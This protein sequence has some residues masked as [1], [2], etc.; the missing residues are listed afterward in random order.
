M[1]EVLTYA[2]L[3]RPQEVCH[4]DQSDQIGRILAYRAIILIGKFLEN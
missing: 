2:K 3:K 1:F 4:Q